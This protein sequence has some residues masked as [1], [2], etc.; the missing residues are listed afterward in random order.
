V[1]VGV[2]PIGLRLVNPFA[3]WIARKMMM[4]ILELA[5]GCAGNVLLLLKGRCKSV[6][7]P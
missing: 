2:L 1:I 3:M 7:I 4:G 6:V 5:L